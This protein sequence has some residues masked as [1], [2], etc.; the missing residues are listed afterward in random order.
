MQLTIFGATGLIGKQLVQQA[1]FKGY[2]VRAYGRNVFTKDLPKDDNLELIHGT[3]FDEGEVYK[4]IKG[5]D[6][7]LSAVGGATDSTDKSRSLGMKNIIKQMEKASVKRIIAVSGIGILNAFDDTYLMDDPEFPAEEVPVS[8]EHLKAFEFLKASDLNWTLVCCPDIFDKSATG[9]FTTNATYLPVPNN[10]TIYSGD[11]A[12][13]MI[14][15]LKVN[16]YNKMRVGIS[17]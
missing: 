16:E 9:L 4:A 5:S 11:V 10:N 17:N 14:N 6:A 12:L 2:K 1:L 15:E 7:I 3:L 8:K 13:F